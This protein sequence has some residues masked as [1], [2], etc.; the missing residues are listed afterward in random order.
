MTACYDCVYA[1]FYGDEYEMIVLC[2]LDNCIDS[3]G[4]FVGECTDKK[5]EE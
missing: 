1:K 5:V 2:G 3:D 4:Y